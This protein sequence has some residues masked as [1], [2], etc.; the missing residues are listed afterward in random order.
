MDV[1]LILKFF[2]TDI[3]IFVVDSPCLG[4]CV[5]IVVGEVT[6][7]SLSLKKKQQLRNDKHAFPAGMYPLG[8]AFTIK[9]RSKIFS[10]QQII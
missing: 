3:S 9:S 4:S 1:S 5:F 6:Q 8:T 7:A 2:I 10:L